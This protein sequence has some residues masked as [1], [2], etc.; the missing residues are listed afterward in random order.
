M[1]VETNLGGRLRNTYLPVSHSLLPLFEA[2]VNSIHSIEEL[3]QAMSMGKIS[4]EIIRN[5]V[6]P[7]MFVDENKRRGIESIPDIIGFK[8]RDNGIGFNEANFKSFKILDTDYKASKGC[9]GVG[10]LMWLKAFENVRIEST[11]QTQDSSFCKRVITL[12]KQSGIK[13][14]GG[15]SIADRTERATIVHLDG[16]SKKY[17]KAAKKSVETISKCLFEHCIWYF[18]R[19][20]GAPRITVFDQGTAINLVDVYEESILGG[21]SNEQV[22]IK[23]YTFDL[24]FVRMR[25]NSS[26][27]HTISYCASNRVV[28]DETI[29][30]KI[31][32]LF[33]RIQDGE[34]SFVQYCYVVSEYLDEKVRPERTDFDLDEDVEGLFEE[35][36][37]SLNDI[38]EEVYGKIKVNLDKF[39]S[40]GVVEAQERVRKFVD[41]KA[42]KYRPLLSRMKHDE[43]IVD[44]KTTDKDLDLLLHKQLANL[45]SQLIS[46]GHELMA[47][48]VSDDLND[49]K[50]RLSEYLSK[51][52]DLKKSDLANYISHRKVILDLFGMAIRVKDDGKY[53]RE[54]LIHQLIVP[55]GYDTN[56]INKDGHN[57]WLVDERLAFHN[58][59]ASD[60]T[61]K[62]MPITDST[63]TKEP[64]IL[65]LRFFDRPFLT[66]EGDRLPLASITVIEIK[67]PMRDDI[68]SGE[69]KDPIEQALGYLGR[70]RSGEIQTAQ[71]RP[72]PESKEI[73]GFCYVLADLSDSLKARCRNIHD[74]QITSD[75]MGFFGYKKN[76]NTYIEVISFDRLLNSARERNRVFFDRLGLPTN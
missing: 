7:S 71:G 56:D 55:M 17:Q 32:G 75:G 18:L 27:S 51:A 52:E 64:D 23:G 62:S 47:P 68:K 45:E 59:L 28:K 38:R 10:R 29:N 53:S 39:L 30:G 76:S 15:E 48:D 50:S 4:V 43:L 58:Y 63:A 14:V 6:P 61:L 34:A 12:D 31:P 2:V 37:V 13:E 25:A 11:Y 20:G 21:I 9:R 33:G 16:F 67:R 46:D 1:S 22:A 41:E 26:Q 57:L 74:L 60:K 66:A 69:E 40:K 73:P 72:I 5:E 3:P 70:I 44:P 54:D 65:S 24:T 49:Y 35:S 36:Q 42:P 19:T 8:I